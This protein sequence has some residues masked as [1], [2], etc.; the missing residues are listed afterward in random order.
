MQR[1]PAIE[2]QYPAGVRF[3]VLPQ[4]GGDASV[5]AG[6]AM[7]DPRSGA[8]HLRVEVQVTMGVVE[9]EDGNRFGSHHLVPLFSKSIYAGRVDARRESPVWWAGGSFSSS[10]ARV[11]RAL[12]G[13]RSRA[14]L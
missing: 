6:L 1:V 14:T 5:A 11:P 13:S 8:E 2:G 3:P 12:T 4:Q 9:L 7:L 10:A